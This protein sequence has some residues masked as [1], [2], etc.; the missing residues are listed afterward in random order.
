MLL[1]S[2]IFLV[3]DPKF[4]GIQLWKRSWKLHSSLVKKEFIKPNIQ[5]HF[6]SRSLSLSWR[7]TYSTHS[8]INK[9]PREI[10]AKHINAIC[11]IT[12]MKLCE[13]AFFYYLYISKITIS[14][15]IMLR[16]GKKKFHLNLHCLKIKHFFQVL[17]SQKINKINKNK[18]SC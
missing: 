1:N 2:S 18:N 8:D 5:I 10:I 11:R 6:Y 9:G 13:N 3:K 14:I 4:C 7:R 17:L 16:K 12:R 15:C